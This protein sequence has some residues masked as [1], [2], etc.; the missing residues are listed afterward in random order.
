M[1]AFYWAVF[2]ACVWGIAPLF[3]KIGLMKIEPLCG[4]F[5]RS[6]G[7]LVGIAIFAIFRLDIVKQAMSIRSINVLY[8]IVG[9]ILASIVGQMFFYHALK[10]GEA[11]KV[12]PIA[13]T[14]PLVAFILSVI[15]LK[16]GVTIAKLSGLSCI[17]VGIFLL[18]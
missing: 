11:S 8:I 6:I 12:V 7:V 1:P 14:Y 9:G 3:E 13:A 10:F 2:A 4:V 17:L 15:F 18:K 5:L 16:E